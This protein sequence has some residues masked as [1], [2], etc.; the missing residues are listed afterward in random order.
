MEQVFRRVARGCRLLRL[1]C[2]YPAL[3]YTSPSAEP[4]WPER[5]AALE[6]ESLLSP[7][8]RN[9][10]FARP[11]IESGVAAAALQK[12]SNAAKKTRQ[13]FIC[14]SPTNFFDRLLAPK[15]LCD[16]KFTI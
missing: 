12:P 7:L 10:E 16:L 3:V 9:P 1:Q 13:S 2:G 11:G 5:S 14:F 4:S 15:R 8:A 6:C